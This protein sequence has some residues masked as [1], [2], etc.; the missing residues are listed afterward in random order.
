MTHTVSKP[1][2]CRLTIRAH[3]LGFQKTTIATY[4]FSCDG[5]FH[6]GSKIYTET[7]SGFLKWAKLNILS[8][9]LKA[10]GQDKRVIVEADNQAD[11]ELFQKSMV[12]FSKKHQDIF[13]GL[14]ANLGKCS[15]VIYRDK[16]SST[17][18]CIA[19]Q[20]YKKAKEQ[21]AYEH[22]GETYPVI[23]MQQKMMREARKH[24]LAIL[25]QY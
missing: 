11:I 5:K 25:N 24:E 14:K 3:Y 13:D 6:S 18:F 23:L 20:E 9:A 12:S 16:V 2:P 10:L 15:E 1:T 22:Y 17:L 19:L 4:A 21:I 7:N 8:I